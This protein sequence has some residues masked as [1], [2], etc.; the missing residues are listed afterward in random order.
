M[1]LSEARGPDG[2]PIHG[3][4]IFRYG[5]EQFDAFVEFDE[6]DFSAVVSVIVH[7]DTEGVVDQCQVDSVHN[8]TVDSDGNFDLENVGDFDGSA[9][10]ELARNSQFDIMM[11]ADELPV[12]YVRNVNVS[13]NRNTATRD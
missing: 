1:R 2:E 4:Y 6:I 5:R 11:G 7:V 8:R 3:V 10:C 13:I 12:P 9:M